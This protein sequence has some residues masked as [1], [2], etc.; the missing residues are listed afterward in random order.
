MNFEKLDV[1]GCKVSYR[2]AF[3]SLCEVIERL[4]VRGGTYLADGVGYLTAL[5]NALAA[6]RIIFLCGLGEGRFCF[7]SGP[8][9]LDLTRLDPRV[10]DV[11]P[12]Q[13]PR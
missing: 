5:G 2:I 12:R 11:N 1:T 13:T 10:G 3:E 8:D 6:I 7:A 4:T 9:P